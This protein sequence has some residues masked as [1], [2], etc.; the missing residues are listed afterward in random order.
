MKTDTYFLGGAVERSRTIE[1]DQ[2]LTEKCGNFVPLDAK[3]EISACPAPDPAA[4]VTRWDGII[5]TNP[6]IRILEAMW[7]A[8][9][10]RAAR[11][12][13]RV[14]LSRLNFNAQGEA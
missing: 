3:G 4:Y 5:A 8:P 14:P 10:E 12:Q 13:F 11:Q 2:T 6:D 1:P 9:K 7:D